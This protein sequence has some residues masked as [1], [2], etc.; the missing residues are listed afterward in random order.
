MPI[1]CQSNQIFTECYT[2]T[3]EGGEKHIFSGK[4][5]EK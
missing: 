1:K 3:M 2:Y 4:G 5:Q